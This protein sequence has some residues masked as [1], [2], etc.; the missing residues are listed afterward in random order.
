MMKNIQKVSMVNNI[1][2]LLLFSM[3][4]PV[5]KYEATVSINFQW[6]EDIKG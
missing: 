2:F 3:H 6:L 4:F 1:Y 5:K